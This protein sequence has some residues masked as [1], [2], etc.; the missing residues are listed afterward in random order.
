[1]SRGGGWLGGIDDDFAAGL[2][3]QAVEHDADPD[4]VGSDMP[5]E[6]GEVI[7]EET[8]LAGDPLEEL[9]GMQVSLLGRAGADGADRLR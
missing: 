9:G 2:T 4:V 6:K 8:G 3:A 1:M 7:F 5:G